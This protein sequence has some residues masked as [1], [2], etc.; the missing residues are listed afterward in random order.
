MKVIKRD[1]KSVDYDREKIRIAIS[2]A[3][4][5]VGEKDRISERQIENIIKSIENLNKK[6]MLVEDIQ[7]II[8][9]KIMG[10]KKYALA[11][12]YITYRYTRALVRKSNTTDES[13]LSLIRNTSNLT[14]TNEFNLINTASTQRDYIAGEVSRDLTLRIL[15][16][17]QISKAHIKG[18]IHFHDAGYFVQPIINSCIINLKDMLD[19]GTIINNKVI[20]TPKTFRKA[21]SITTEIIANVNSNTYG[22]STIYVSHLGK[23]L[24]KSRKYYEKKIKDNFTN[25]IDSN[26][27]KELVDYML[28]YELKQGIETI[29]YQTSTLPTSNGEITNNLFLYLNDDKKYIEENALIFEELLKLR[30]KESLLKQPRIVYV[31]DEFNNLTGGKYDYITQL[32]LELSKKENVSFISAKKMKEKY[33]NHV[34]APLSHNNYLTLYKE[35]NGTYKDLGRFNTGIVSINL[36]NA[37]LT[38]ERNINK[39]WEILDERLELAREALIL[40]HDALLG[41]LSDISEILWQH[42]AFARLKKG[43]RINKYLNDDYSCLSLGYMGLNELMILF[44]KDVDDIENFKNKVLNYLQEKLNKWKKETSLGFTLYCIPSKKLGKRFLNL[45]KEK[46]G[47]IKGITDKEN[48]TNGN[49]Y[50]INNYKD[51]INKYNECLTYIEINKKTKKEDLIEL[52]KFSEEKIGNIEIKLK[53]E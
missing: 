53:N 35:K 48:Y 7:D 43:E 15:L 42:G 24:N 8:E 13:L 26:I 12:E 5:C 17:E 47:T 9:E 11:K 52:I 27:I 21:C 20:S 30:L 36:V 32:A 33:N 49:Y 41:T 16:P 3:N 51:N 29:E 19:N 31:I 1:G 45:D 25:K 39:F 23:Y 10:L 46:Y 37:A 4:I 28:C 14:Y 2:K 6:R 44:N 50:T 38:S 22:E 18:L 34:F 40:R